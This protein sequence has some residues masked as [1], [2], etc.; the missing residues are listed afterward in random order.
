MG[1]DSMLNV[2]HFAD[3]IFPSVMLHALKYRTITGDETMYRALFPDKHIMLHCVML[4]ALFLRTLTGEV[5]MLKAAH[6]EVIRTPMIIQLL[7][8]RTVTGDAK[9]Y[10]A[11]VADDVKFDC[12]MLKL[13]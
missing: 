8:W 4:H 5:S 2:A 3:A 9:M 7:L 13:L 10:N 6:S 12:E 1:E 11:T